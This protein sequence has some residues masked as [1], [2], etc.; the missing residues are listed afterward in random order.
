[1]EI[2]ARLLSQSHRDDQVLET[3]MMRFM[4]IIGIVFWIIF[5]L[6]KSIPFH[7]PDKATVDQDIQRTPTPTSA[8][9]KVIEEEDPHQKRFSNIVSSSPKPNPSQFESRKKDQKEIPSKQHGIHLQFQSLSDLMALISNQKVKLYGRVMAKGFDLF[10]VAYPQ[11]NT[12]LFKYAKKLPAK[13]WKIK[14]TEYHDY[15][16]NLLA[17]EFPAV[18]SFQSNQIMMS[19]RDEVL[20]NKV[21][22]S[23]SKLEQ[24][25]KSGILSITR[26]GEV[27]FQD[28]EGENS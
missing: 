25:E 21:E 17:H 13:L 28:Y 14:S 10:F 5:A 27:V 12:V 22:Q 19:F 8:R 1:M 7:N 3:D 4:A 6:I 23:L 18:R 20:E 26:S 2:P 9:S 16:L 15:F 24:Q 11:G